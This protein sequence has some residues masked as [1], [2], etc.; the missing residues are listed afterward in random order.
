MYGYHCQISEFYLHDTWTGH[1]KT[2]NPLF[3]PSSFR[4]CTCL[5]FFLLQSTHS[6]LKTDFFSKYIFQQAGQHTFFT[7]SVLSKP[8]H[9]PEN[10]WKLCQYTPFLCA[11]GY[12]SKVA[13][14][15]CQRT[16]CRRELLP[17]Q[18]QP[19]PGQ[20]WFEPSA[21]HPPNLHTHIHVHM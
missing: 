18:G 3:S 8:P 1:V 6:T 21:A 17:Q 20:W 5:H 10:S 13:W 14:G 9:L 4:L 12:P 19:K 11:D 16:Q 15:H 7:A 2:N